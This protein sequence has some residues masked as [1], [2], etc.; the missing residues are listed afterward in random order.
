LFTDE[1]A[2]KKLDA[3]LLENN[4]NPDIFLVELVKSYPFR[5]KINDYEQK[6]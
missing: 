3:A 2:L 5:M 4:F 6:V 1:P